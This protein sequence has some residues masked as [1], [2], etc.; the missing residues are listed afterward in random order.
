MQGQHAIASRPA[1]QGAIIEAVRQGA[2]LRVSAV[3]PA[4][5][6]EVSVVGP[7]TAARALEAMAIRRLARATGR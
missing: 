7:A 5:G 3:C 1:G 6:K 4:T 2:W